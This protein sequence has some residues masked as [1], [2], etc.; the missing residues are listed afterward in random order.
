MKG[1][2]PKPAQVTSCRLASGFFFFAFGFAAS[3][4]VNAMPSGSQC[5]SFSSCSGVRAYFSGSANVRQDDRERRHAGRSWPASR[6]RLGR[7]GPR[8]LA[9]ERAVAEGRLSAL[10]RLPRPERREILGDNGEDRWFFL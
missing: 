2:R 3:V 6:G 9:R 7:C 10:L 4:A 8:R 5:V 1:G